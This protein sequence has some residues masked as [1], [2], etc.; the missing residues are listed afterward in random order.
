MNSDSSSDDDI[1]NITNSSTVSNQKDRYERIKRD[2]ALSDAFIYSV[3]ATRACISTRATIDNTF[4][5]KCSGCCVAN[6]GSAIEAFDSVKKIREKI[7]VSPDTYKEALSNTNETREVAGT[8]MR[9]CL[10]IQYLFDSL[11]KKSDGSKGFRFIVGA[12]EVCKYFFRKA[13]GLSEKAFNKGFSYVLQ[14]EKYDRETSSFDSLINSK[15]FKTVCGAIPSVNPINLT[16]VVKLPS[17]REI[18]TNDINDAAL[19]FLDN[20]F[21]NDVDYAPEEAHVRYCRC[22]WLDVHEKYVMHSKTLGI[23]FLPYDR[24]ITLRYV[25]KSIYDIINPI[26]AK[27]TRAP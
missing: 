26:Y 1:L 13:S 24:F 15:L 3:L 10:F 11:I 6:L 4:S 27:E 9:N 22:R 2:E 20:F 7:W 8:K 21:V 17:A 19:A 14:Y 25:A 16:R 23:K 5:F 18:Q 12:V